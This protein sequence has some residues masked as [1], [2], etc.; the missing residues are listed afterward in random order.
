[1]KDILERLNKF[2]EEGLYLYFSDQSI[3]H[4]NLTKIEVLA[5]EFWQDES[6]INAAAKTSFQFQKCGFCSDPEPETMC[7]GLK[8]LLPIA[9]IL[10]QYMSNDNVISY[11]R[12]EDGSFVV[13]ETN[14]QVA[15]DYIV[16]L[17]MMKFCKKTSQFNDYF[18]GIF[19]IGGQ[20]IE[21]LANRMYLNILNKHKG[22]VPETISALYYF[23]EHL[24]TTNKNKIRR[25]GMI[26]SSDA[27]SKAF[28]RSAIPVQFFMK[29]VKELEQIDLSLENQNET[30]SFPLQ[31]LCLGHDQIDQDHQ[32]LVNALNSFKESVKSKNHKEHAEIIKELITHIKEHFAYEEKVMADMLYPSQVA[33]QVRHN[34]L[35]T[36]LKGYYNL[37]DDGQE[38]T[39]EF[40]NFC[41]GWITEHIVGMDSDLVEHIN[42]S[43]L[44]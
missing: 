8:P 5:D 44:V 11:F 7:N 25:L 13:K 6:I 40:V 39:M 23:A 14:L 20:T 41:F 1:M 32:D 35:L 29:K 31:N 43:N 19:N 4:F 17:S 15:L 18:E 33:H 3:H 21:E 2:Q 36:L 28:A 34:K 24:E 30:I 26:S 22:N 12:N 27:L 9:E 37:V 42:N 38:V 10:D 16:L